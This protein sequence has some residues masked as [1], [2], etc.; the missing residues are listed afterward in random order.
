MHTYTHVHKT[1]THAHTHTHTHTPVHLNITPVRLAAVTLFTM[2][3]SFFVTLHNV[4][5]HD[6]YIRAAGVTYRD[7]MGII[8]TYTHIQ[9]MHG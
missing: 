6:V 7:D 5:S 4:C 9:V 3:S 2:L 8:Y 1:H